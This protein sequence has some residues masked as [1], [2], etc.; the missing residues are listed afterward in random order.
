M[1]KNQNK[2][3]ENKVV[4]RAEKP[5]KDIMVV[6]FLKAFTPYVKDEIAGFNKKFA[7]KL[8]DKEVAEEFT[9]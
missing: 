5:T 8:I 4:E 2:R 1:A 7:Y 6:K 3:V 9:K